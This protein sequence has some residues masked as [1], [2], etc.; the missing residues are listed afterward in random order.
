M[1]TAALFAAAKLENSLTAVSASNWRAAKLLAQVAAL[2]A[3]QR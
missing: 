1:T 3:S 2:R